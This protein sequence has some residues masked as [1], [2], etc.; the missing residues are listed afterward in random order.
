MLGWVDEWIA[1][2]AEEI[3]GRAERELE[4]LVGVSSPSGDVKGAEQVLAIVRALLPLEAQVRWIDTREDV[5]PP[6][7][8]AQVRCIATDAPEQE[9]AAL[10]PGSF[11]LVLT[12]SHALDLELCAVGLRRDDLGFFGLIGSRAKRARFEQR[13]VSRGLDP[14]RLARLV[15]PIGVA[16]IRSKLPAAIAVY[17]GNLGARAFAATAAT[18]LVADKTTAGEESDASR[19]S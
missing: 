18:G 1:R 7:L 19:V 6:D 11:V 9:I 16:G 14:L 4:A 17:C 2:A 15:C 12:H 3:A 8:A 5:F 10:P 13:L